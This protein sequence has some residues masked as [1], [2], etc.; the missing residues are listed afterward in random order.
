MYTHITTFLPRSNIHLSM[1]IPKETDKQTNMHACTCLQAC[2]HARVNAHIHKGNASKATLQHAATHCNTSVAYLYLVFI[3]R[4]APY[5]LMSIHTVGHSVASAF[6]GT[7][8]YTWAYIYIYHANKYVHVDIHTHAYPHLSCVSAELLAPSI[9]RLRIHI[10]IH[11]QIYTYV[12]L[13]YTYKYTCRHAY[14]FVLMYHLYPQSWSLCR[15]S[16]SAYKHV[17]ISM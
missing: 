15:F 9:Q 1:H 10:Y 6:Q 14:T 12:M 16:I 13:I 2:M 11:K 17:Y 8:K 7:N 5:S 3:W 4:L